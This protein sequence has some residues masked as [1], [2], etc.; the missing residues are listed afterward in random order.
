VT[1][2]DDFAHN[3]DKISATLST[4]HAF[5]GRLLVFFQPHGFG[6]LR[7]MRRELIEGFAAQLGD[8]DV[9]ILSDPVYYGGT[10]DKSVGSG[11]IVAGVRSAGRNA[12]HLADRAQCSVRL[13]ELA[14]PGDRIVVMGARDDTLS[15]FAAEVLGRLA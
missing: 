3:P 15:A 2:I 5:P 8:E 13:A 11:D 1:V 9:L 7:T 10:T 6:P 4:L 12:E 14:R